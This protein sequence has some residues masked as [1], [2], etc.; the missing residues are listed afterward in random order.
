MD[1]L[2]IF[3][4]RSDPDHY[5]SVYHTMDYTINN[6]IT[7]LARSKNGMDNWELITALDEEASQVKVWLSPDSDD[8]LLAYEASP[9][10]KGNFIVIKQYPNLE[11]LTHRKASETIIFDRTLG[12]INE[13]TP[14]FEDVHFTG[15]LFTS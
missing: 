8:I 7:Y 9:G 12:L 1:C 15:S 14:S 5:Y 3:Q 11:A 10:F 2:V 6:F 4:H 13:G